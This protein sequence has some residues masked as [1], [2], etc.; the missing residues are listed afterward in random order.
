[1]RLQL[2]S[3]R[4]VLV[5]SMHNAYKKSEEQ[6]TLLKVE[7]RIEV[8]AEPFAGANDRAGR[9]RLGCMRAGGRRRHDAGGVGLRRQGS[10]QA[11][12]PSV[13]P[14]RAERLHIGQRK[15]RYY[16]V[17]SKQSFYTLLLYSRT[18]LILA[19]YS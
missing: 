3:T 13:L 6:A 16:I 11:G 17:K 14:D 2:D 18:F 9:H 8:G 19:Y 10:S 15:S 4:L 1:M 12:C 5:Q 7:A